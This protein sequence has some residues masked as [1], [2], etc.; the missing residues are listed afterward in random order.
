MI[1]LY[2]G[3]GKGKTCAA[4]GLCL[5]AVG[6]GWKAVFVQFLKERAS[7]EVAPLQ[8][9]GVTVIRGKGCGVFFS[10]MSVEQKEKSARIAEENLDEAL[11]LCSGEEKTLLVLDEV[12]AALEYNVL[13]RG[14][15]EELLRSLPQNVELVLTGRNPPRF[16]KSRAHYVTRMVKE[17]HPFD[18]GIEARQGIEF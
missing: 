9:A 4:A 5:R 18:E 10:Q 14:K 8:K 15:I 6:Q 1:H 2:Y 13:S 3:D 11:R 12:C 17:A 16:L 7:G